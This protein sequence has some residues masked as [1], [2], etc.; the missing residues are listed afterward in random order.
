MT[1]DLND[2][3]HTAQPDTDLHITEKQEKPQAKKK[4]RK[5]PDL[6]V[7]DFIKKFQ[8]YKLF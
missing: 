6:Q 8:T 1:V 4:E 5:R 3:T 7:I 2:E